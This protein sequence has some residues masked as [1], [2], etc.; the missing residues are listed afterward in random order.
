VSSPAYDAA[1]AALRG[2]TPP[3]ARQSVLREEFVAHL[4]AHPDGLERSCTPGHLTAGALVLSPGLDRVLLNLHGKAQ[5][6]FHF[7]GHHEPGDGSL[8]ATA[9]REA[10]E[11][12]GIA[13][14]CVDPE[15]VHLDRHTVGFC[16]GSGVT[17]HLDVRYAA[18]APAGA[19][20]E[21]SEESLEVR[22]WPLDS[23][24]PLEDEMHELIALARARLQSASTG[25]SSLAPAE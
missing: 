4:E 20:A 14:L 15:P 17:D 16:R 1:L 25:P 21:V 12:S 24:P 9:A 10:A 5:R 23:L 22:W 6:W 18:L 11:E 2:W 13:G 3:S 8:L 19:E 7:G